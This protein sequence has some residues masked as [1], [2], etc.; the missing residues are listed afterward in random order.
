MLKKISFL[1]LSALFSMHIPTFSEETIL[2]LIRHGQT[3]WNAE[4]RVQGQANSPLNELGRLQAKELSEKLV[5]EHSDIS[6]VYSSDLDRAYDTA[7]ETADR[8][9]LP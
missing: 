5:F 8:F 6:A 9:N 7:K 4:N 3:D 2:I 1:L